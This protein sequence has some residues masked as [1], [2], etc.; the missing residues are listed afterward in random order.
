ML[1]TTKGNRF[2]KKL[3]SVFVNIKQRCG[4]PNS[5]SYKYYG[6]KG[7]RCLIGLTDLYRLWIRDQANLMKDP[8]IDRIDSH[9]DYEYDN[10]QFVERSENSRR[11]NRA[12]RWGNMD[13]DKK[14]EIMMKREITRVLVLVQKGA[15]LKFAIE[16]VKKKSSLKPFNW[17]LIDFRLKKME[18]DRT[19]PVVTGSVPLSVVQSAH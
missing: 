7:I 18:L 13:W 15:S 11:V 6:G 8:T 4:N 2:L 10:C 16:A 14:L 1:K 9:R 12:T 5:S 19:N 3:D 17:I